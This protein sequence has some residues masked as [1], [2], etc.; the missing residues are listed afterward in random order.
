MPQAVHAGSLI[1]ALLSAAPDGMV[2][3]PAGT[4]VMGRDVGM[5]EDQK[6]PHLVK[7]SAFFLDA[8][9]VTNADFRRYV[10][11]TKATTS[12]EILGWGMTAVEGMDDWAW[13]KRAGATW[14]APWG[15]DVAIAD[16]WPVVMVSWIDADKYCRHLGKR[17]PT[18]AEWEY[19]MRAGTTTMYPWGPTPLLPDGGVGLNFWQGSHAK[20]ERQD[21]YVYLSP[22]R[23][24][25]PNAW[26]LFDPVGNVW[27]WTN[28]WYAPDTYRLHAK[29]VTNPQG[30]KDGKAKV[31]RGGSWWCSKTTCHGYGL[32]ARGK[33]APDAPYSNNGFR[34][35]LTQA[36]TRGPPSDSQ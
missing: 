7:V 4:F 32:N 34:C 15:A 29:G 16:D 8:T 18:E 13:D 25:A 21:P 23:A 31:A 11:Q 12:A 27:Q 26:G 19:A 1:C 6:P 10:A 5:V 22:V 28:D 20:N 3:I 30:P 24:F 2:A 35:A 33:T 36:S 9:L 14:R 17:L